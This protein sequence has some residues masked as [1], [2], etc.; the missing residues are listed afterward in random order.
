VKRLNAALNRPVSV[1]AVIETL[2]WVALPY[3]VIGLVFSVVHPDDVRT[4]ETQLQTRLPAGADLA[5]FGGIAVL[6]PMLLITGPVEA[7][8]DV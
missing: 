1:A 2:M 7:H 5:A 6:W 4:V 8:C 3:I